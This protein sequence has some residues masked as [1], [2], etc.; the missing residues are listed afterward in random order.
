MTST[1]THTH[2][3]SQRHTH[4]SS[5]YILF[6]VLFTTRSMKCLCRTVFAQQRGEAAG[7]SWTSCR[8]GLGLGERFRR[9]SACAK[10]PP[11]SQGLPWRPS[12]AP[13]LLEQGCR[14]P[15][16]SARN[17]HKAIIPLT[18]L[19]QKVCVQGTQQLSGY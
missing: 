18:V 12:T 4:V 2:T 17:I 19:T 16:G 7:N 13:R 9:C 11:L 6:K 10:P 8:P 14:I 3:R 15:A 1:K 5:T